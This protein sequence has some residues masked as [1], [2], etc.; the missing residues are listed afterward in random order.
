M[1]DTNVGVLGGRLTRDASE[2]FRETKSGTKVL[3]LY[4]ANNQQ[5]RAGEDEGGNPKWVER[6][7]FVKVTCWNELAERLAARLKKGDEI[8][9]QYML[10]DDN[11]EL[12]DQPGVFTSGRLKLE[13]VKVDPIGR[14]VRKS[15]NESSTQTE[16]S[17]AP[18]A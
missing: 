14:R 6:T 12:K 13:A 8:L 18:V 3:D 7:T 10:G 1:S 17:T 15:T 2:G 11:F 16:A 9:V 4:V 5:R